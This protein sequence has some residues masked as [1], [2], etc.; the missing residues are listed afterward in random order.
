M[1]NVHDFVQ[2]GIYNKPSEEHLRVLES[3]SPESVQVRFASS[4]TVWIGSSRAGPLSAPWTSSRHSAVR[5]VA[6]S[7]SLCSTAS[8]SSAASSASSRQRL[9]AAGGLGGGRQA[10]ERKLA[11][12][13]C[14]GRRGG[15]LAPMQV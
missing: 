14:T 1:L 12:L 9:S 4:P 2:H 15:G 8:A 13:R 7:L 3:T 11:A 6:S 5:R 10:L